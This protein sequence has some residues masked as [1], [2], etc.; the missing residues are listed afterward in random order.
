MKDNII[1]ELIAAT[2]KKDKLEDTDICGEWNNKHGNMKLGFWINTQKGGLN[3][4]IWTKFKTINLTIGNFPRN[5]CT[6]QALVRVF[7][8][9]QDI[10]ELE[11]KEFCP[12]ISISGVYFIDQIVYPD[13]PSKQ[14]SWNVKEIVGNKYRKT[15][16]DANVNLRVR[17]IVDFGPNVYTKD[18][19]KD[20]FEIRK[21]KYEWIK[22]NERD[23][24]NFNKFKG[25]WVK[26]GI[27]FHEYK[28]DKKQISF[29][30]N[31]LCA[32]SVLLERKIFFPYKRWY[33]RCINIYTAILDLES[34][35]I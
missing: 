24:N 25:E 33:L 3:R 22:D 17:Y 18:L 29:F 31:E 13:E 19:D 28:V 16:F 14:G 10:R 30:M 2:K 35:N 8:M 27:E 9:K 21:F 32:F 12:Y 1:Q 4:D 11:L 15:E 20:N 6:D 26:D 23:D 34:K 5:L 7:W